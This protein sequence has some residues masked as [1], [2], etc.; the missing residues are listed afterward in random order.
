MMNVSYHGGPLRPRDSGEQRVTPLELFFDLVYV[1]AVTRL[2]HLVGVGLHGLVHQLVRP[3]PA[4]G[5]PGAGGR[6]ARESANVRR[7]PGGLR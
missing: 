3:R 1:F 6:D 2:S 5:S 7:D 4:A